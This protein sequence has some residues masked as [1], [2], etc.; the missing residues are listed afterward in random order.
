MSENNLK[1]KSLIYMMLFKRI[2][3]VCLMLRY[4]CVAGHAFK[5]IKFCGKNDAKDKLHFSKKENVQ[6]E[7]RLFPFLIPIFYLQK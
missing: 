2:P 7:F 1:R 6:F 4:V 3:K 5:R